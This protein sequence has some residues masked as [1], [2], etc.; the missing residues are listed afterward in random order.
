MAGF[1]RAGAISGAKRA[2]RGRKTPRRRGIASAPE[3]K[4]S[5]FRLIVY[6]I[7]GHQGVV[8]FWFGNDHPT[9]TP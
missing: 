4:T 8:H 3:N 7:V 6:I 9:R 2:I 5:S 1:V